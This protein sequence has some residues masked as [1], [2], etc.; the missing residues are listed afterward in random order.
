MRV[1]ILTILIS[2]SFLV[3]GC[4]P[5]EAPAE[6]PAGE[7]PATPDPAVAQQDIERLRSEW[8]AAAELDDAETVAALYTDDAVVA[9]SDGPP[10]VG[11]EAIKQLWTQAFPTASELEIRSSELVASGELA[12]DYGEFSQRITPAKGKPMD[13]TGEYLVVLE[14][15]S[16][17]AWKIKR[18]ISVDRPAG[19]APAR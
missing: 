7:Q 3:A 11:R 9:S 18:H 10:A 15:Q 19:A 16:D 4:Q 8:I 17:G 12:Y 14:R 5:A 1:F 6:A 2:L 13:V